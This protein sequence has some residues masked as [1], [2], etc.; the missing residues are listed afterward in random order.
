M[1]TIFSQIINKSDLDFIYECVIDTD[2]KVVFKH[3]ILKNKTENEVLYS[4]KIDFPTLR[5][6]MESDMKEF[7][8]GDFIIKDNPEYYRIYKGTDMI[9]LPKIFLSDSY[10]IL[11]NM[12]TDDE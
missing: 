11:K 9:L 8:S 6:F 10:Q 3:N 2:D 12:W 1:M 4:L 5:T 7:E